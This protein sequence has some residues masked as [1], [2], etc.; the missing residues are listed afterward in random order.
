[1]SDPAPWTAGPPAPWPHTQVVELPPP[2]GLCLALP[3]KVLVECS[4]ISWRRNDTVVGRAV[5]AGRAHLRE[6]RDKRRNA[7]RRFG[8]YSI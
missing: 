6:K 2:V 7:I 5:A 3:S 1:L 4:L 8:M